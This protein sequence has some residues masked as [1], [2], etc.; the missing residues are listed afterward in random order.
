MAKRAM[1]PE[2]K[3][4][5]AKAIMDQAAKTRADSAYGKAALILCSCY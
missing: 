2:A 4:L 3:A 5:K 1:T